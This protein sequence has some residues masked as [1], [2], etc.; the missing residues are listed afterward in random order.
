MG[1][2]AHIAP[3]FAAIEASFGMEPGPIQTFAGT[4]PDGLKTGGDGSAAGINAAAQAV[5]ASGGCMF[6]P[7]FMAEMRHPMDFWKG[8]ILGQAVLAAVYIIFG[9]EVYH[10][11]GQFAYLPIVQGIGNYGW[12]TALNALS[13]VAGLIATCLYT[14]VGLKIAYAEVL[15]PMGLPPLT[16][17]TGKVWWAI[18][19]PVIWAIG[20]VLAPAIP[21]LAYTS[22]FG[23][24]LFGIGFS[25]VFPALGALSYFIRQDAVVADAEVFDEATR[26]YHYVDHGWKRFCR[27]VK[28]RPLLHLWNTVYLICALAT[29]ILGCYTAIEQLILVFQAGVVTS[30]TCASPV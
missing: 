15:Q 28:K 1:L 30:F 3:N 29:C 10:F 4:P 5:L 9:M 21:Q 16:T 14:N 2:V 22:S 8:M 7:A 12:Q 11:Y 23:G 19:V 24:A 25:Y 26:T 18:L 17:K 27:A 13:I 20:F 6:F